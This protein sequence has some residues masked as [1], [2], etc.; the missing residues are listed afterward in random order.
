MGDRIFVR[1]HCAY[2]DKMNPEDEA[3]HT[4]DWPCYAP[5]SNIDT[6][7]CDHCGKKNKIAQGFTAEKIKRKKK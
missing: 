6:F 1:L 2:C 3:E 7:K 5:S 4:W